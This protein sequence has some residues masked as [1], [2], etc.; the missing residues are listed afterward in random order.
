ML[1]LIGF[2]ARRCRHARAEVHA[3]S[4]VLVQ[5]TFS[6]APPRAF[7]R[8]CS[9]RWASRSRPSSSFARVDNRC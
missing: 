6:A 8:L 5:V 3:R 4:H 7:W 9:W 1:K 2:G